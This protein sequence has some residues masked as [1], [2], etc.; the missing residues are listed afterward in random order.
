MTPDCD[1]YTRCDSVK[2]IV[3]WLWQWYPIMSIIPYSFKINKQKW[4]REWKD[5]VGNVWMSWKKAYLGCDGVDEVVCLTAN[6]KALLIDKVWMW[7]A[8]KGSI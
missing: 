5:P 6:G 7:A 2:W 8:L 4:K 3:T 1:N